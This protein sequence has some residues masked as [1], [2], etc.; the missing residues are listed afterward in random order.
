M[1]I[2]TNADETANTGFDDRVLQVL[3]GVDATIN[4]T[5][6]QNGRAIYEY[7]GAIYNQ[8]TLNLTRSTVRNNTAVGI[9]AIFGGG[10]S[11]TTITQ[12]TVNDNTARTEHYGALLLRDGSI[13]NS[14][15]SGNRAN[16]NYGGVTV[17]R[18]NFEVT[19]STI[20]LNESGGAGG[21]P[22]RL[23]R[24]RHREEHHS[25]RQHHPR[26]LHRI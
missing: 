12:S 8:G 7:G 23:R 15:V 4:E 25:G 9:G 14:T 1:V 21:R 16:G 24:H 20:A 11:S 6:I 13:S 26:V 22:H 2:G 3:R 19:D 18:G 17:D 5:T 10:D